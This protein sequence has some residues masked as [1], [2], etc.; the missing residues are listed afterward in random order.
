MLIVRSL[1]LQHQRAALLLVLRPGK[2]GCWSA[3]VGDYNS[4]NN[5]RQQ[6]RDIPFHRRR[7]HRLRRRRRPATLSQVFDRASRRR[8]DDVAYPPSIVIVASLP[9]LLPHIVAFM[10][11]Q[12]Q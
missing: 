9:S 8:N 10:A 12:R 6:R 11:R 7:R 2:G 4:D 5:I 3:E 1:P